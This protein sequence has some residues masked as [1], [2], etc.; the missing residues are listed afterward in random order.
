[1]ALP[2]MSTYKPRNKQVKGQHQE[3]NILKQQF[4]PQEPNQVWSTDFTYIS[5]GHKKFVYLCAILDL[6]S[7][8]VI[9]WKIGNKIDAQLASDTL[10]QAIYSRKPTQSLIFH[11]DQGSQFKSKSFRQLLDENNILASYSKPG[12]PYDNAVTEVFFKYLKERCLNRT[13]FTSLQEVQLA[14]F[15][16]IESFYNNYN[17]HSANQELTPN[18]KEEI[19]FKKMERL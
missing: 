6:F 7:R 13:S 9:A 10:I 15:E 14:C 8:K 16:Y 19:Y 12:Y 17:P 5:I 3:N 2:K 11:S 4:N 1:M 18:Q